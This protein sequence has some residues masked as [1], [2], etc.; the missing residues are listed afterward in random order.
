MHPD[1]DMVEQMGHETVEAE[2]GVQG[3]Q[4]Y[5]LRSP[6]LVITD[7]L[8]NKNGL[9]VI[10]ELKRG[11]PTVKIIA[12]TGHDPDFLIQA[13]ALGA[14]HTFKKPFRID[15]LQEAIEDLLGKEPSPN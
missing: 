3:L 1:R 12:I 2:D 8:M 9:E 4:L 15:E 6:D 10:Q 11:F 14:E 5:R 7:I 13:K